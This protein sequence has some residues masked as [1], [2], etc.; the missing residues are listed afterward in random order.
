MAEHLPVLLSALVSDALSYA[1]LPGGALIGIAIRE[2][3]RRR[4]ET[5]R[6]TLLEELRSGH[7]SLTEGDL[8]EAVAIIYRY[9]RAAQEG[10]ARV[11]LRLMAKVIA[12]QAHVGNL[13]SSEFLYYADI[14]ASLRREEVVLV[15][16]LHRHWLGA[17]QKPDDERTSVAYNAARAE[18]VP[19]TF[20]NEAA[21]EATAGA[22]TR[23]GLVIAVS[24]WGKLRY[25][26]TPLMDQVEH[27]APFEQALE[28]EP[29]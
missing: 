23:T 11:N 29:E 14:L 6:N 3:F 17:D 27:L 2:L 20:R 16:T 21:L 8:E 18:L 25:R 1:N 24:G 19:A 9:S 15:G 10:A 13:V 5:A 4:M 22:A 28:A 12:N 7:K 26:T